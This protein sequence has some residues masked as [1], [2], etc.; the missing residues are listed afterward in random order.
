[1]ATCRL[2]LWCSTEKGELINYNNL[3]GLV[4]PGTE[5]RNG[6]IGF[7]SIKAPEPCTAGTL[8]CS[9]DGNSFSL[10]NTDGKSYTDMGLVAPGTTCQ[11]GKIKATS[12]SA[13]RGKRHGPRKLVHSS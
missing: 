7:A 9:K 13:K 12:S 11:D 8:K 10:C 1:M 4:A 3:A 6:Q 2:A 5:C